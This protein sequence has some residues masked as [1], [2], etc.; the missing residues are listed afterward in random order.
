MMGSPFC[1]IQFFFREF[2]FC[3]FEFKLHLWFD[4]ARHKITSRGKIDRASVL[5]EL[6]KF[7]F[8]V[9]FLYCYKQLQIWYVAS[10][11]EVIMIKTRAYSKFQR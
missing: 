9:L 2:H 1:S 5:G 4:K 7:G 8:F 3:D 10:V 6:P 11:Y